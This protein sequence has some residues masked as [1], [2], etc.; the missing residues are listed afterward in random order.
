VFPLSGPSL[1]KLEA[2]RSIHEAAFFEAKELT[3]LLV[4]LYTEGK[5]EPGLEVASAL[6]ES[7][8]KRTI[9]HADSEEEGL[10]KE[11]LQKNPELIPILTMLKRDHELLR[12]IVAEC[13]TILEEQSLTDELLRNFQA[14]LV[15]M[16]IHSR[17]EEKHL[18]HEHGAR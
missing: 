9:A 12:T 3:E 17:E 14:L 8:E 2:H 16:Q 1:R 15:V 13:K 18:L 10:Y 6:V 7:W 11:N 5:K 4:K